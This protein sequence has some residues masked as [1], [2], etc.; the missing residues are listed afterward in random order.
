MSPARLIVTTLPFVLFAQSAL[1]QEAE[2]GSGLGGTT[3]AND[4]PPGGVSP[5]GDPPPEDGTPTEAES[6]VVETPVSEVLEPAPMPA[7][8]IP[9]GPAEELGAQPVGPLDTSLDPTLG[10]TASISGEPLPLDP[11]QTDPFAENADLLYLDEDEAPASPDEFALNPDSEYFVPFA[12][13]A[14]S[15]YEWT[16]NPLYGGLA[17]LRQGLTISLN[18]SLAYSSNFNQSSGGAGNS[19][20]G[21]TTFSIGSSISYSRRAERL[22]YGASLS[23]GYSTY[24]GNSDNNGVTYN[25]GANAGYQSGPLNVRAT[26]GTGK[27][28]GVN[29]YYDGAFVKLTSH[30]TSVSA[31]YT[32][33]PKTSLNANL[34]YSWTQPDSGNFGQTES[35]SLGGAFMWQATQFFSIGPGISW[36]RASGELQADRESF[37]PTLSASYNPGRRFSFNGTIGL[38]FSEYSGSNATDTSFNANIGVNYTPSEWWSA[39]LSLHSGTSADGSYA[40][41]FRDSTSLRLGYT[42]KIS[43]ASLSLGAGYTID[44]SSVPNGTAGK[45][46]SDHL[47]FDASMGIPIFANRANSSIFYSWSKQSGD[48]WTDWT[49]HQFGVSVSTSF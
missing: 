33:S 43:S 42:R 37:G 22:S 30:S 31:G 47:S 46:S 9:A 10:P 21:E 44:D 17:S 14:P 3:I 49:G 11:A 5:A 12:L 6:A 4:A 48:G 15:G 40:G 45:G 23:L 19:E 27:S 35:L 13:G 7:D 28:Q 16:P 25:F 8:F 20:D 29:R 36:S 2:L 32:L 34:G 39:N 41:A 26:Y 24:F 18:S 38:G 1:A